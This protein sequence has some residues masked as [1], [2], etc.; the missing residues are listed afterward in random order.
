MSIN[1]TWNVKLQTPMG[2]NLATLKLANSDGSLSGSVDAAGQGSADISG[3]LDG[4]SIQFKGTL[5]SQ[6]GPIE[7][8][9]SGTVDGDEMTGKVELGTFGSGSWTATK[10]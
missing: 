8:D 1:G 4:E 7:L 2:E 5:E 10:A 6:M 3:T 9:F